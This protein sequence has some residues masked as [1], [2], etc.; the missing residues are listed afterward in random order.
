MKTYTFAAILAALSATVSLQAGAANSLTVNNGLIEGSYIVTFKKPANSERP[1]ITPPLQAAENA[2]RARPPFG[3]HGTGQSKLEV[4]SVLGLAGEVASIYET[5][6]AAHIKMDAREA[7]RLRSHPLVLSVEQDRIIT[8]ATTQTNPGWGLDR[9]DESLPTALDNTYAYT[10]NGAGQTI[11][12]LD[13]GLSLNYPAVA[14]EFGGR[15]S[16]VYDYNGGTG[17]DCT[18]HGTIVASAAGGNTNGVAKGVSLLIA[19][20]TIGCIDISVLTTSI[21]AFNWL[22]ANAPKGTIVNWSSSVE[23]ENRSCS[24]P[25]YYTALDS[26]ITAA[27]NAGI[28]VVVAAGND[29]CNTAN[30]SPTQIPQAFVVG[31]TTNSLLTSGKDAKASFS[32]TGTNIST[33]T[34]GDGISTINQ[35]GT[36]IAANGTSLAAPY[37]AGI[38]AIACQAAAP[39]CTSG[40]TGSLYQALRNTATLNTVTNTDGTPLTGATSRFI[41]KQAW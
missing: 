26:A 1:V 5:I 8:T 32:R 14:S 31:A 39:A 34:P 16:I 28:I 6:N 21:D 38:F 10:S 35:Y 30:F 7:E 2:H 27:H 36:P 18:G 11:Y 17:E 25:L 19:K 9:L 13:S 23:N 24:P 29:G 40:D 22:A 4:A 15:A 41:W 3:E 12:I 33:F 20:I 37:I